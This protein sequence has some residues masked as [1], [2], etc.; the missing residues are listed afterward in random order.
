MSI[1]LRNR[2]TMRGALPWVVLGLGLVGLGLLGHGPGVTA[3]R[4]SGTRPP[5]GP[6]IG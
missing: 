3:A 4:V 2:A 1:A 6:G 5:G